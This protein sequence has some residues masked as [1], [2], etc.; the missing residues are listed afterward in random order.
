MPITVTEIEPNDTKDLANV[1]TLEA[2]ILGNLSSYSDVDYYPV[3]VNDPGVLSIGFTTA[4]SPQG[5]FGGSFRVSVHDAFGVVLGSWYTLTNSTV[6]G[7]VAALAAGIYYLSVTSVS[8]YFFD[9]GPYTLT[10]SATTGGDNGYEHESNETRETATALT[11]GSPITGRLSFDTDVDYY[12][13]QVDAGDLLT[14]TSNSGSATMQVEDANGTVLAGYANF[15]TGHQVSANIEQA[16]RYYVRI[17]NTYMSDYS[18]VADVT[19]NGGTGYETESNNTRATANV[20]SLDST[21]TGQLSSNYDVDYF[22]VEI[23]EAGVLAV[24]SHHAGVDVEDSSGTLLARAFSGGLPSLVGIAQAGTYYIRMLAS[25]YNDPYTVSASFTP[26]GSAAFESESNDTLATADPMTLVAPISGRLSTTSDVDY[27]ALAVESGVSGGV[28]SVS[29]DWSANSQLIAGGRNTIRVQ[30]SS[31]A[32][33]ASYADFADPQAFNVGIAASGTYYLSVRGSTIAFTSDPYTLTASFADGADGY[34]TESNDT[35]ETADALV[36]G[37]QIVGQLSASSDVDYFATEVSSA[38]ILTVAFDRGT[39]QV[40]DS[41][42]AALASVPAHID[43]PDL[44]VAIAEA[45]TYYVRIWNSSGYWTSREANPYTIGTSF[46]PADTTDHESESN[47]TRATADALALGA[48]IIGQAGTNADVDYFAVAVTDRGRLGVTLDGQRSL[49]VEDATGKHLGYF[50]FSSGLEVRYVDVAQAGTCYIRVGDL[51]GASYVLTAT[52]FTVNQAPSGAVLILGAPYTGSMLTVTHNLADGDGMGAVTYSWQ[53]SADGVTWE[54]FGVVGTEARMSSALLDQKIRVVASYVDGLGY[55]E[56][57]SSEL[58]TIT[59]EPDVAGAVDTTH[60]LTIGASVSSTIETA[61]D[62]DYFS[63]QLVADTAYQFD[64]KDGNYS[65]FFSPISDPDLV[66]RS[67]DN[68]VLRV[69]NDG[70]SVYP[71]DGSGHSVNSQIV[72][73]APESGSYYLDVSGNAG[74]TGTYQ[75]SATVLNADYYVQSLLLQP[76]L[77]WNADQAIGT[78]DNVTFSFPSSLPSEYPPDLLPGYASFSAAQQGAAREALLK[79]SSYAGITFTEVADQSGQIRFATSQ[80]NGTAGFTAGDIEGEAFVRT[81]VVLANN[82]SSNADLAIG[83]RGWYVLLHE[84]EHALGL[85][86]PGNYNGTSGAEDSPFLPASQD[87]IQFTIETYNDTDLSSTTRSPMVFDVAALQ[88]L[89]GA[90]AATGAGNSNYAL[91]AGMTYTVWDVS[92]SDTL[93]ASTWTSSVTLDLNP[94]TVSYEGLIGVDT[95]P[96]PRVGIA[97]DCWI[98]TAIGGSGNDGISGNPTA[99]ALQGGAGN[100][101]LDGMSGNDVLTGGLGND[102]LLGG[103]GNDL[104]DG[105]RGADRMEGGTGNDLYLVDHRLD[106]VTELAESGIDSV[107][108]RASHAL[109]DN[110]ENLYLTG[111]VTLRSGGFFSRKTATIDLNSDGTGNA[112]DNLLRGNRGHNELSGMGGNDTLLGGAGADV[113]QG[114]A[115]ADRLVGGAGADVFAFAAGD[116]GASLAAADMLYDFEDGIDRIALAGGLD[117]AGLSITQGNGI[118]TVVSNSVIRAGS[119]EYLVVLLNVSPSSITAADFYTLGI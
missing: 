25:N 14:V 72:F 26:G 9:S 6:S 47:N 2:A 52:S 113:L 106:Q 116:G 87:A 57:V 40:E 103:D 20:I 21:V 61:T 28:L 95:A 16:G 70:A 94:G 66:L 77:R 115:G 54:G 8:Q 117:F 7:N 83:T 88:Y 12:A 105:G 45:G 97:F 22:T 74:A 35:R 79:I 42:G 63:V 65:Y 80:Q 53:K 30:D 17:S 44:S 51:D 91:D 93:D 59:A 48:S 50:E 10:A 78:A 73:I 67:A 15:S 101:W 49:R 29:F 114:G 68:M 23:P 81:E 36:V 107:S 1:V 99:N 19:A 86:H 71:I 46:T 11:L 82:V 85:K 62:S 31:G 33:L 96:V 32:V 76:N 5:S 100:D 60:I 102:T 119:G 104:L 58:L 64:L 110:V 38:G 90:N 13:V 43:R 112:S 37:E 98:E 69:D 89:Y 108:A 109:A 55:T 4:P 75:L 27:Y 34:E 92:G 84:I 56:R 18:L 39:M 41:T 3:I 118:D 24:T 111:S